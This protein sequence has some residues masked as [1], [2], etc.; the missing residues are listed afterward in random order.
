M[1]TLHKTTN[2]TL[3]DIFKLSINERILLVED[4]WDTIVEDS[5]SI[6]LSDAQKQEL[7]KRLESYQEK[8][9]AGSSWKE[10]KKRIEL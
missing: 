4:L 1:E 3:A 9:E 7:D 6:S 2:N 5:E 10:V 8:P